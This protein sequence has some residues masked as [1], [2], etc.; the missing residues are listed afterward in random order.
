MNGSYQ[1]SHAYVKYM[2]VKNA[3]FSYFLFKFDRV[4]W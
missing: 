3:S 1:V 2:I 4:I